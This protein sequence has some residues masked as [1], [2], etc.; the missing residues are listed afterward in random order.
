MRKKRHKVVQILEATGGGGTTRHLMTLAMELDQSKF[1]VH[2]ICSVKRNQEFWKNIEL[3]KSKKITVYTVQMVRKPHLWKDLISLIRIWRIFINESYDIVHCHSSKAGFLGRLAA[4]VSRMPLI[5]YTP[6]AFAF[7]MDKNFLIRGIYIILEWLAGHWTDRL[8]CVSKEESEEALRYRLVSNERIAVI[9]NWVDLDEFGLFNRTK[10]K[11]EELG[12]PKHNRV[13]GTVAGLRPQ[14]G[15]EFLLKAVPQ[16]LRHLPDTTFLIIGEGDCRAKLEEIVRQLKI[17]NC[18]VMTGYRRDVPELYPLMDVY[19][20]PSLW[21]GLPYTI[22][23]AMACRCPVIATDI[24]G[25]REILS[26]GVGLLVPPR[27]PVLLGEAIVR[28]LTDQQL[29]DHLGS[30]G[31]QLIEER[32]KMSAQINR[33]EKVYEEVDIDRH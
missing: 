8:I 18:V 2:V 33:I 27:S 17:D 11:W 28:L 10:E 20:L 23:E 21:E 24:S 30:R 31:R 16:V 12:I 9:P 15:H 6:H 14:K 13:V 19:V 29:A 3:L 22:L 32:Y 7:K 26:D 4:K 25:N 5:V 1:E